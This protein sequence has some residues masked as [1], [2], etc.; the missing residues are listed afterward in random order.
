[1]SKLRIFKSTAKERWLNYC[2]N[3]IKWPS[4][5]VSATSTYLRASMS[6]SSVTVR[7]TTV[8]FT[9]LIDP[10]F[11]FSKLKDSVFDISTTS[12][13]TRATMCDS[14]TCSTQ[15]C[16]TAHQP[17]LS[18]RPLN[19]REFQIPDDPIFDLSKND[20]LHI[21]VSTPLNVFTDLYYL[22]TC[23]FVERRRN[24]QW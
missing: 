19:D 6:Y 10:Y 15:P 12:T 1:M 5:V 22:S 7:S 8:N 24:K 11:D 18:N 4:F 3:R 9:L 23:G 14:S 17:Q 13:C 21:D 16:A 2:V 20:N